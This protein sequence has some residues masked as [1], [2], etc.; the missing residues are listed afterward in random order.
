MNARAQ[1]ARY[2]TAIEDEIASLAAGWG[3][4]LISLGSGDPDLETPAH[5][6]DAA[7]AAIDSGAT[8]YTPHNGLPELRE[9]I[10]AH[11]SRPP[12]ALSYSAD[13]ICTTSGV[14]EAL[15]VSML[16]LV[17]PGDEILCPVPTYVS[18]AA[19]PSRLSQKSQRFCRRTC[20]SSRLRCW[21]P[22]S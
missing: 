5:I 4:D 15:M 20:T 22:Q 2:P 19:A 14:Q 17:G 18:A 21:A 11:L 7:K 8:H 1:S 3:A 9:A 16:A 10:S 13:E 6:R 12:Y